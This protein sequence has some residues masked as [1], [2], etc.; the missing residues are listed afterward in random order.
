[1]DSTGGD[2]IFESR[3]GVF[4]A[5]VVFFDFV[6]SFDFVVFFDFVAFFNFIVFF[7]LGTL[8]PSALS[9]AAFALAA[10]TSG[11]GLK[12]CFRNLQ[13]CSLRPRALAM[14][15]HLM[16]LDCWKRQKAS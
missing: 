12:C 10:S 3:R 7:F 9:L 15:R 8:R 1:M 11:V 6:V 2:G 14:G 13:A 16:P 5:F 4:F